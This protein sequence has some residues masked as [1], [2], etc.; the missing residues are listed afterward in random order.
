METNV[1]NNSSFLA[2][3]SEEINEIFR[4]YLED[5]NPFIVQ[6]EI[7]K[8]EFPIELQN[9]IRSMYGHLCRASIATDE[10]T[11][12]RNI[13]KLKS[14]SKRALLD[15]Y[16]YSCI[17]YLDKYDEFFAKYRN[18]DLT[19]IDNG[20]FLRNA[21]EKK[22][23][24]NETLNEAK[25]AELSNLSEEDLLAKYQKAFNTAVDL[26]TLLNEF[27]ESAEHLKHKA[28]RK[29]KLCIASFVVGVLG[30]IVGIVG[31]IITIV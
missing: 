10:D 19:Y 4:V 16:K 11:I 3:H 22:C 29:D 20:T 2:N 6:F 5:I 26:Y 24:L 14:H 27:E 18:I 12:K 21:E 7:L 25:R 15:C 23:I 1:K 17:V 30:F 28:A 31:I 9:E 13:Q 8:N